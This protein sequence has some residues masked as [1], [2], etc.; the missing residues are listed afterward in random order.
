MLFSRFHAPLMY[1][2]ASAG[3]LTCGVVRTTT[4]LLPHMAAACA[5]SIGA[6]A[7]GTSS[8]WRFGQGPL[9]MAERK[10]CRLLAMAWGGKSPTMITPR[11]LCANRT[12]AS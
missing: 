5:G 2:Q 6:D 12:W 10:G 7:N 8:R 11:R 4:P 3:R 1:D 9:L